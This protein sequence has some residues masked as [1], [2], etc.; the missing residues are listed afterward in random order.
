[1][2]FILFMSGDYFKGL[3]NVHKL[4][5]AYPTIMHT[6]SR[7][8][9]ERCKS[10]KPLFIYLVL[11]SS[12]TVTTRLEWNLSILL[13]L[14]MSAGI[15]PICHHA[16]QL[17]T[18]LKLLDGDPVKSV[19]IKMFPRQLW[20]AAILLCSGTCKECSLVHG[21]ARWGCQCTSP[22]RRILLSFDS[23]FILP[24]WHMFT[25]S[26]PTKGGGA[27]FVIEA[28]ST[29]SIVSPG[30][31]IVIDHCLLTSDPARLGHRRG[32]N[33]AV[34]GG[35]WFSCLAAAFAFSQDSSVLVS[36]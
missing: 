13:P 29:E 11:S 27:S 36:W 33:K 24:H 31:F 30:M 6:I 32:I 4:F 22:C 15:T 23:T 17:W 18:L 34:E 19:I 2:G 3:N 35:F 16:W 1:M 10:F 28:G 21:G 5:D 7:D 14:Q 8:H 12:L 25:V 9:P 20:A 26:L